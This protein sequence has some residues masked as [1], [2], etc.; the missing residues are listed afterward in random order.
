MAYQ[1]VMSSKAN[2]SLLYRL[3]PLRLMSGITGMISSLRFPR[4]ILRR[5]IDLYASRYGVNTAEMMVPPGGFGTFNDFFTRKLAAG[6]RPI[7]ADRRAVVSPVDGRIDR[8]GRIERDAMIQAKGI[9][10]S[11]RDLIPSGT[12]EAFIDGD[13]ITIYLSPGDYH[14]IHSPVDG[15]IAGYLHVPGRL[16]SVRESLVKRVP[17]LYTGNERVVTYIRANRG[18][19]AVCKVGAANVGAISLSYDAAARKG[20]SRSP[21]ESLYNA[22]QQKKVLRGD[23]LG[24]FNL[25]STVI[26]IFEKGSVRFT[27]ESP[28]RRIRMGEKIAVRI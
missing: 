2:M 11:L 20:F 8:L 10:Y 12:A 23:E 6:A 5:A 1:V 9:E 7:D 15:T 28:G 24:V 16:L 14:R 19:V 25:G 27:V 13:F 3:M 26:V 4:A 17:G 21:K 22:D 18:M